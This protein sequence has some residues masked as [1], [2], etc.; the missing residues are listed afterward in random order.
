[1][2]DL[3]KLGFFSGANYMK[4]DAISGQET[5]TLG[6]FGATTTKTAEHNLGYIPFY[7]VHTEID[8]DDT[9]WHS[10]KV[11][12]I[13]ETSLGGQMPPDPILTT[14]ITTT[15]LT[16]NLDNTTDPAASGTRE[17]YWLIYKDYGSTE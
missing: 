3:S 4:R 16:I 9:I 1:M 14:W 6:A 17:V 7:E 5:L 11:Y 15:D 12:D 13:T 2:V 8:D 10:T